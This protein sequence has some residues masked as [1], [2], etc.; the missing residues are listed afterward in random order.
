MADPAP[1]QR[2]AEVE[3]LAHLSE[4]EKKKI[5]EDVDER[6]NSLHRSEEMEDL[7]HLSSQTINKPLI[8]DR[9][10]NIKQ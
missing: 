7:A 8:N 4:K 2:S 9:N 6:K 5:F 10:T 3:D 1:I